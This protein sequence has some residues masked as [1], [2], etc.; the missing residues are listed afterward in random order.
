MPQPERAGHPEQVVCVVLHD[1]AP[2][3]WPACQSL[4]KA[5]AACGPVPVTFLAVPHYHQGVRLDHDPTCLRELEQ[6]LKRGDEI[7]LHGY[8]H[9]DQAGPAK[10]PAAW[11][12]RRLYTASEG[13]FAALH[14]SEAKARIE[15]GLDLMHTLGWPVKGFVAPAWLMSAGTRQALT[16]L[17]LTYTTTHGALYR[18]PNW[19][20]VTAP[21]LVWSVRASWRRVLSRGWNAYLMRRHAAAPLLRLGL[22]PADAAFPQVVA[23]WQAALSWALTHR[24]PMTKAGWLALTS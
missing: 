14:E 20:P 8:T 13:E 15:Q 16:H 12:M 9:L 7:A 22:H 17:P 4:L 1:V 24:T 18:L 23:F 11:A 10:R 3:T 5:L 6:R 21:G 19:T 2:A